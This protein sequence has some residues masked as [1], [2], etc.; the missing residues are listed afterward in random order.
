MTI[1]KFIKRLLGFGDCCQPAASGAVTIPRP[2]GYLVL[3][4]VI[5]KAKMW[6]HARDTYHENPHVVGSGTA[7]QAADK[8]LNRALIELSKIHTK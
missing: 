1:W 8:A 3:K 7:Y 5:K 2:V 6:K 4:E